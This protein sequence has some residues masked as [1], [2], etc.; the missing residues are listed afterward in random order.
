MLTQ[1]YKQG[2]ISVDTHV[3]VPYK[4]TSTVGEAQQSQQL[5]KY[6]ATFVTLLQDP[7]NE[8]VL[9]RTVLQENIYLESFGLGY[10]CEIPPTQQTRCTLTFGKGP[11][12]KSSH[13]NWWCWSSIQRTKPHSQEEGQTGSLGEQVQLKTSSVPQDSSL[14]LKSFGGTQWGV[15]PR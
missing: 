2:D 10:F 8:M 5:Q 9:L 11:H 12:S 1:I 13:P 7:S 14:F 6:D 15:K 3:L 4:Q